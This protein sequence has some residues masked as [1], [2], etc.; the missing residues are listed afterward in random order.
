M[1]VEYKVANSDDDLRQILKLQKDNLK[2]N[3]TSAEAEQQGFVTCHHN[4]NLL[5]QMNHPYPHVIAKQAG[6]LAGY[7]LVM[8]PA[9]SGQIPEITSL[10]KQINQLQW[11]GQTLQKSKYF[12]MGQVCV[13]KNFR[14]KSVFTGLYQHMFKIMQPH[15]DF[16]ITDIAISNTRSIRA[17]EKVGF[18]NIKNYSDE[19]EDWSVVLKEL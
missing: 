5:K 14:G 2:E 1:I 15:F 17:H 11:K 8:L 12:V 3:V 9:F 10:F 13:A 7:A 19:L 16:I 4:F 18:V 6:K